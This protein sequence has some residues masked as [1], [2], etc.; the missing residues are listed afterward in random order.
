MHFSHGA[1]LAL[2]LAQWAMSVVVRHWDSL[3]SSMKL[4]EQSHAKANGNSLSKEVFPCLDTPSG[5]VLFL[6]VEV[7]QE[8]G[9]GTAL[10]QHPLNSQSLLVWKAQGW[11]RIVEHSLWLR[12]GVGWEVGNITTYYQ[13]GEMKIL[14]MWGSLEDFCW[15]RNQVLDQ[16]FCLNTHCAVFKGTEVSS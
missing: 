7:Q 11:W 8:E 16:H 5:P 10:T 13:Y 6:T 3:V 2:M 1:V 9:A 14:K 12:M 15:W 4:K